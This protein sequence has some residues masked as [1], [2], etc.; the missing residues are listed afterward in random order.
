MWFLIKSQSS[1]KDAARHLHSYIQR[2]RYLPLKLRNV[3]DEVIQHNGYYAH[4]ENIL[5]SMITDSRADVKLKA[6]EIIKKCSSN[7]LRKFTV[8]KINF[9]SSEYHE[10]ITWK[11][12][13]F[14]VPPLLKDL[15][16]SEMEHLTE[17][18]DYDLPELNLPSHTQ[19]VERCVKLV[20]ESAASVSTPD[21]RDGLIRVTNLSRSKLKHFGQSQITNKSTKN[22]NV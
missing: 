13:D 18:E 17:V 3:I 20:T 11:D 22:I 2:T 14:S 6:L 1:C 10:M 21:R 12:C 5:L 9:K 19:A 8:P 16:S 4:P 7:H 15:S